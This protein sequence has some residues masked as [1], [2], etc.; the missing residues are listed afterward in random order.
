MTKPYE[1][2]DRCDKTRMCLDLALVKP[3][4]M[5]AAPDQRQDG[6][7]SVVAHYRCPLDHTWY[8]SWGAYDDELFGTDE[9]YAIPDNLEAP[10]LIR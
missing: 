4:K 6:H 2:L 3:Y 5:S 9:D 7:W 10:G 1:F 8:T